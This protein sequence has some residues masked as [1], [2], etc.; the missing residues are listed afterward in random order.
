MPA[1][2]GAGVRPV[3]SGVPTGL[4][5]VTT[6]APGGSTESRECAERP[7]DRDA[8]ARRRR[9][10]GGEALPGRDEPGRRQSPGPD[11]ER[12]LEGV[13]PVLQLETRT[14]RVER[15]GLSIHTADGQPVQA[16]ASDRCSA[17]VRSTANPG[18]PGSAPRPTRRPALARPAGEARPRAPHRRGRRPGRR[19][20]RPAPPGRPAPGRRAV[21]RRSASGTHTSGSGRS[22]GTQ[23][24]GPGRP[25]RAAGATRPLYAGGAPRAPRR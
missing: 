23:H 20:R 3:A 10:R 9:P 8:P 6:A 5:A 12:V 13:R 1:A 15:R 2:G 17:P 18:S 16:R 22:A 24:T 19:P 25:R 14:V 21:A 11:V 7:V 4:T